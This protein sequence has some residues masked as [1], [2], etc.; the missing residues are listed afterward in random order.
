MNLTD[1]K[2]LNQ[3]VLYFEQFSLPFLLPTAAVII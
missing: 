2:K 1:D 3:F